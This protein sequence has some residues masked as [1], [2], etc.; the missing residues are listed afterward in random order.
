MELNVQTREL[1]GKRNKL[2]R[3]KWLIPG[4]IYGRHMANTN[5]IVFNKNEFL[6]LY[7][8]VWTSTVI[9]LTWWATEMVLIHDI[10]VDHITNNLLHVDFLAVKADEEVTAQVPVVL[11][12]ESP[13]VKS[14]EGRIDLLRDSVSV[15]ALPRSLP[16]EIA[17][18]ISTILTLD[19]GF[20]VRD[21]KLEKGVTIN[22]ELDLPVVV[23]VEIESW[24]E[25]V[26]A[27]PASDTS[28]SA[29]E[30]TDKSS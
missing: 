19:D 13:L 9:D 14:G 28:T 27:V 1:S 18:D 24:E 20:F 2:L 5:Q 16:H 7:K 30:T 15:T 8:K 17:I 25:E 29:T 23:A 21:I 10:Q 26:K 6:K 3:A 22:E 11:V 4:V 12:G